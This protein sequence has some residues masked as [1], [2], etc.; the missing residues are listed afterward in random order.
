MTW[1][2]SLMITDAMSSAWPKNVRPSPVKKALDRF[3]SLTGRVTKSLVAMAS[4]FKDDGS[5]PSPVADGS[6]L[7]GRYPPRIASR[8]QPVD[9]PCQ[10]SGLAAWRQDCPPVFGRRQPVGALEQPVEV[11]RI[12]QPPARRYG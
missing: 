4:S 12:Q 1:V 11:S 10:P 6:S 8:C 5:A 3:R 9:L 7:S 2:C